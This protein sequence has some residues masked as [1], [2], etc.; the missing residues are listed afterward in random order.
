MEEMAVLQHSFLESSVDRGSLLGA[1]IWDLK[2]SEMTGDKAGRNASASMPRSFASDFYLLS[3]CPAG[4]FPPEN[5]LKFFSS[6]FHFFS[7]LYIFCHNT[8]K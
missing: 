1:T 6:K 7:T 2:Q 5:F 8:D 4:V 3:A